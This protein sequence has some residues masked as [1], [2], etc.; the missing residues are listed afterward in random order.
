MKR[1]YRTPNRAEVEVNPDDQYHFL[2]VNLRHNAPS[3]DVCLSC[4]FHESIS[5]RAMCV[6]YYL[7]VI[8]PA[9]K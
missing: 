3:L 9:R 2:S 5:Y 7:F 6:R 8:T 4:Y 1:E